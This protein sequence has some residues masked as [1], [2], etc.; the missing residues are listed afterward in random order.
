MVKILIISGFLGCGK[1]QLLKQII[2]QNSEKKIGVIENEV[3]EFGIDG[4]I[5]SHEN[6]K[7]VE[8]NDGSISSVNLGLFNRI[9][10][11]MKDYDLIVVETSG[12]ANLDPVLSVLGDFEVYV[13]CV[14]DA[15][16]FANATKLSS[17]TLEHIKNAS[18]VLLN[19]CDL[20]SKKQQEKQMRNLSFLNKNVI[21]CVMCRV[22]INQLSDY[23]RPVRIQEQRIKKENYLL[24][25]IRNNLG[26]K[27]RGERHRNINAY[28]YSSYGRINVKKLKEFLSRINLPRA[29][30]FIVLD[31]LFYFNFVN[32][33]FHIQKAPKQ[34][35]KYNKIVLI[36]EGVFNKR[37]YFRGELNKCTE[38]N[39]NDKFSNFVLTLKNQQSIPK[40]IVTYEH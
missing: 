26:I 1:T 36:G 2:D 6:I 32:N 38:K 3:A 23:I 13:Y 15:E 24:W 18:V 19:K 8:I 37:S 40:R 16:R 20:V 28:V 35:I 5:S 25:K 4:K 10:K 14:I 12:A 33:H 21:N 11:S 17:H 9:V 7:V 31:N 30:G 34:D 22:D 29:K 27:K 39:I